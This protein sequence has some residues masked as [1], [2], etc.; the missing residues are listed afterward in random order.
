MATYNQ[1]ILG[2]FSGKVGPVIGSN[3]RGKQVLRSVPSKSNKA[4]SLA[5]Q[6]QRDKFAF[7]LRFLNP[8]KV[9]LRETFGTHLDTKTPFNNA[10]SYHLKEAVSLTPTG[11]E[12]HYAKVLIGKGAL[13]GIKQP[14]LSTI[15]PNRLLLQWQ[16]NSNQGMAYANDSLLVI[17]Y[18]PSLNRFEFFLEIAFREASQA[19]LE[20]TDDFQGQEL[21]LWATFTNTTL[22]ITATSSYVS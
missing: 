1:G 14:E 13:C 9:V 17:V 10:L 6:I 21:V 12:M 16:D 8:I 19:T 2:S 15:A 22:G 4:P 20:F 3:W 18:A 5:Q 11:F 7:V